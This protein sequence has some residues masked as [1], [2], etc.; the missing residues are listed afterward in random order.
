[1]IK[2]ERIT[3]RIKKLLALA[4]DQQGTPEGELSLSQAMKLMAE[5]GVSADDVTEKEE[6]KEVG[7]T[8]I[9]LGDVSYFKQHHILVNQIATALN[10]VSIGT[11]STNGKVDSVDVFGRAIDRE[12]VVMLYSA[13][14]PAMVVSAMNSIPKGSSNIR[15]R[16]LSYMLGYAQAIHRSLNSH[17]NTVRQENGDSTSI[18]LADKFN[19]EKAMSDMYSN[20][21]TT[22][23]RSKYRVDDYMKGIIE[24]EKFDTGS[25]SRLG[26]H[27]AIEA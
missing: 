18:I 6:N 17:E 7:R 2:S 15:I 10:C 8:T 4:N 1:M 14:S 13:A 24:G 3:L 21:V 25:K 27:R 26:S 23:S 12:R 20:H 16:R 22:S 19:A 9:Y 11:R 5:Y